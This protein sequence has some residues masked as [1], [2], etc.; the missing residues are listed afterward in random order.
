MA[1]KYNRS[2]FILWRTLS[3]I[4]WKWLMKLSEKNSFDN[5]HISIYGSQ[6]FWSFMKICFCKLIF[7]K[8]S[9][10]SWFSHRWLKI[11]KYCISFSWLGKCS[12]SKVTAVLCDTNRV[13][14]LIIVIIIDRQFLRISKK[15][16]WNY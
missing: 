16:K 1:Q 14:L 6:S 13:I 5:R 4:F 7:A 11:S 3:W 8:N 12:K 10:A 15:I 9:W 2:V